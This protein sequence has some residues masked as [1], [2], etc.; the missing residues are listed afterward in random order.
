MFCASLQ[1]QFLLHNNFLINFIC[2]PFPLPA[3]IVVI[4]SV[5]ADMLPALSLKKK[6]KLNSAVGKYHR[7]IRRSSLFYLFKH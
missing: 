7:T 5:T 2:I 3:I 1:F 4:Y 6:K